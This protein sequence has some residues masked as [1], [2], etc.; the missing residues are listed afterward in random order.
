MTST[1]ELYD[2]IA[3]GVDLDDSSPHAGIRFST[4][5][6]PLGGPDSKIYPAVYPG[7]SRD[8][9]ARYLEEVRYDGG[10]RVTAVVVDSR[11]SQA[12][13]VEEA[14]QQQLDRG[15]IFLPHLVLDVTS[16]G[17]GLRITS[18]TAP[19]RS[20]D[21]Y[22]RDSR[23]ADGTAFDKTEVGAALRMVNAEDATPML[24]HSPLDLA[25][26][27]WDSQRSLRLA[28]KFPRIYT[29]EIVGLGVER[30]KRAAGRADLIVSGAMLGVPGDDN[31][32]T[33]AEKGAKG[34]KKLSELGH[35]SIPPS[36]V[37]TGG[38]SCK[39]IV[40]TANL[41]FAGVARL[42]FAPLDPAAARAG[43]ALVACLALAGDRLAFTSPGIF[44]RSGCE[45]VVAGQ[46]AQWVGTSTDP[47][48][49]DRSGA[50]GLLKHAV[51]R[52]HAA[53]VVWADAPV[54]LV[55]GPDLQKAVDRAFYANP[56]SED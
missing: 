47:F 21:A 28:T 10:E 37:D 35:G 48:V 14:L 25:L 8:D 56:A 55:P 22:F 34:T 27:A 46:S 33:L 3:A 49:L 31:T 12:N 44:L 29:S 51:D 11:Q 4:E 26:G 54:R 13:R 30:G 40:R 53:G 41:G 7:P 23:D 1:M 39:R 18:L 2:R 50:L 15:A 17:T 38:V 32:W 45:L 5:Y 6:E 42:R 9:P 20:R 16:H 52:L 36:I 43:R 19:H 24:L